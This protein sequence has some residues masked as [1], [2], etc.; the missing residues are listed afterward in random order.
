MQEENLS[1]SDTQ[2][3]INCVCEFCK[4][5]TANPIIEINFFDKK[6]YYVC[7]DC[8]KMNTLKLEERNFKYPK[9]KRM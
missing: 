1:Q 2:L 4:S 6:I 7:K 9:V 8:K 3:K 5:E